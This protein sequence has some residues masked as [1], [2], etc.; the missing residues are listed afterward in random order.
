M[1]NL[2]FSF[3]CKI[4]SHGYHSLV[5]ITIF[6]IEAPKIHFVRNSWMSTFYSKSASFGCVGNSSIQERPSCTRTSSGRAAATTTTPATPVR[7][8]ERSSAATPVPPPFIYR[9]ALIG[10]K[11]TIFGKH[12]F[13]YGSKSDILSAGYP[14]KPGNPQWFWN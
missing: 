4:V 10:R 1:Y 2:I 7:R 14:Q 8:A 13:F 5:E 6:M 11:L 12:C 9:S 3:F